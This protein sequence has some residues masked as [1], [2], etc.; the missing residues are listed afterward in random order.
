MIDGLII[1]NF[2]GGGGASRGIEIAV[3]RSPDYAINHSADAVAMHE[4]NHPA[5]Q[6]LRED[7]FAV[8]PRELVNGRPV[9]VAWFSPDC[10]SFSK[11]KN[12]KPRD[13]KIRCLA[14]VVVKWARTVKPH[15]ILLENVEEFEQW[16]PLDEMGMPIHEKKG[17]TFRQWVGRLRALGYVVEWRKLIAADYGAPTTRRRLFLIARCDGHPITWPTP[18]HGPG[19]DRPHRTAAEIIDWSV[20]CPSIFERKSPLAEP[21]LRRIATGIRRY[22]LDTDNP[23]LVAPEVAGTMIHCG[24]GERVGQ[25]PRIYDIRKPIGTIVAQG[26]KHGIVAAFL[27]CALERGDHEAESH[28]LIERYAPRAHTLFDLVR[29]ERRVYDIG[30][31]MLTAR[32]LFRAQGFPDS[33]VI[34][35]QRNGKP[36][37]GKA[38]NRLAGNSVCPDVAAALVRANIRPAMA[39]AAE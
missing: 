38:L 21:T 9:S 6:H 19:C 25:S 14:W 31:R 29:D 17:I 24:N 3:G 13:Q 28:A 1:D 37:T 10:T 27:T 20:H 36:L 32:E 11:A 16:G 4:A 5:T 34:D 23:Y 15:L 12:A 39:E 2:A 33:Y 7:V 18:T 8:D 30:H 22:V 26:L 35:V